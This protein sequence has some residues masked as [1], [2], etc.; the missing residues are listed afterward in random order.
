M[1]AGTWSTQ[2]LA[3]YTLSGNTNSFT[4]KSSKGD[5][6]VSS[7]TFSCG[8][9]VSSSSFSAVII[10]YYTVR[11][12]SFTYSPISTG[13]LRGKCSAGVSRIDLVF[14]RRHSEWHGPGD[15]I[16]RKQSLPEVHFG[17]K[18]FMISSDNGA[19]WACFQ[20]FE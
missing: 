6:G 1:S 19:T 2:T 7:G 4:M 13:Q 11:E 3:T 10:N 20:L 12:G 16:Y 9:G 5:C 14:E 15:C 8:S 18:R 17:Y